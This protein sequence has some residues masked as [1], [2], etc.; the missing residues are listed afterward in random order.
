MKE[1]TR[2]EAHGYLVKSFI[3]FPIIATYIYNLSNT[4]KN[5]VFIW[6]SSKKLKE[7]EWS[8]Q[9]INII[10]TEIKSLRK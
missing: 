10:S 5:T 8:K 6:R 1:L 4:P 2:D 9:K 3:F 7:S